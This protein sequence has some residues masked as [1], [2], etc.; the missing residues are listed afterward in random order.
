METLEV[1]NDSD[2]SECETEEE[3]GSAV[4]HKHPRDLW[5]EQEE[6]SSR[7]HRSTLFYDPKNPFLEPRKPASR[8]KSTL[9]EA[10]LDDDVQDSGASASSNKHIKDAIKDADCYDSSSGATSTG[11]GGISTSSG[12]TAQKPELPDPTAN[13][14]HFKAL[15]HDVEWI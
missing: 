10:E 2:D 6:A 5:G 11:S 12:R 9:I 14:E 15:N 7:P 3:A 8:H 13:L 1:I 4:G